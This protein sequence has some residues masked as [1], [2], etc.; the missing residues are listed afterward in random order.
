MDS[1][2]NQIVEA[3]D[4]RLTPQPDVAEERSADQR[5]EDKIDRDLTDSFPASDPP[6][7]TLGVRKRLSEEG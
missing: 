4:N 6:G 3:I 7:W 2:H 1:R 5:I